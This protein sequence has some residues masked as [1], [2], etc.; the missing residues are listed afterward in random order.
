MYK[1]CKD[2]KTFLCAIDKS[3]IVR[4]NTRRWNRPPL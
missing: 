1:T 3:K 4:Y 2:T